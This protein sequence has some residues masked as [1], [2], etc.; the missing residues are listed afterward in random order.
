MA[1]K[2]QTYITPFGV[3]QSF[4]ILATL[5]I[6]SI[7]ISLI[8]GIIMS[9]IPAAKSWI[10]LASYALQFVCTLAAVMIWHKQRNFDT[11][12]F[13]IVIIPIAILL[14]ISLS[15]IS[16]AL[17]ALIPMPDVIARMFADAVSL[18]LAGYLTVGVIA[19]V[20]EE[21][22]FRGVILAALLRYYKPAKAIIWSAVIFGIAHLNPWQ[23]IAAFIVGCA[24]GWIFWKTRNIWVGIAMHWVNN[25]V[26]FAISCTT[27]DINVSVY[28]LMGSPQTYVALIVASIIVAIVCYKL[29][30]K[31]IPITAYTEE[32]SEY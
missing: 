29:I 19:P 22:L 6:V 27:D 21:M 13:P 32:S 12:K 11:E 28:D 24:I 2:K 4:A 18:D 20:L 14:T 26:S 7:P 10:M 8:A 30:I 1:F 17:V 31:L 5:F 23:F 16:D 25:T 15:V 9:K 3:G